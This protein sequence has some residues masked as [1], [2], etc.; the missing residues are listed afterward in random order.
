MS[1]LTKPLRGRPPRR[2]AG[3]SIVGVL[4]TLLGLA[5]A[6]AVAYTMLSWDPGTQPSTIATAPIE[7]PAATGDVVIR[8]PEEGGNAGVTIT[9]PDGAAVNGGGVVIRDVGAPEP[10]TLATSANPA[11]LES[12]HYGPIPRIGT[13]GLRPID[14]YLRPLPPAGTTGRPRIAI[15]IGGLGLGRAG[16]DQAIAQLPPEVSLALAPYGSD[17]RAVASDARSAGHEIFLQVPFEPFDFPANDPGEHT[18]LVDDAADQNIDRLEWLMTQFTMYAGIITYAGGRFTGDAAALQ[19]VV[20]ELGRRGLM[21][22]DDGA[23]ARSVTADVSVG[24]VP[25]ARADFVIDTVDD[26]VAITNRLAQLEAL[27]SQRGYAIGS[28]SA[29]PNTI[30]AVRAWAATAL[31]RGYEIVPVTALRVDPA[32]GTLIQVP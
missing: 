23:S 32:E 1:E 26:Q 3:I 16:T 29:F 25:Y 27:A 11:L 12:G 22:L 15:V 20:E 28:G 10:V 21:F 6:G 7:T 9:T 30:E 2:I 19:P 24:I 4:L 5:L 31:A 14:A 13:D 8:A 18:L 17:L